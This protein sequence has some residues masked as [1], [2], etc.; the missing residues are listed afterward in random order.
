MSVC[1]GIVIETPDRIE[2][3]IGVVAAG[4]T[5]RLV[6]P[7]TDG[8]GVVITGGSPDPIVQRIAVEEIRAERRLLVCDDVRHGDVEQRFDGYSV[9]LP[10]LHAVRRLPSAGFE[11]NSY[12]CGVE[13]LLA[14]DG[15]DAFDLQLRA[16]ARLAQRRGLAIEFSY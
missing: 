10:D 9:F 5:R 1:W 3:W 16:A 2:R 14:I 8:S 6:V 4:L 13:R 7:L 15:A 11:T 12:A